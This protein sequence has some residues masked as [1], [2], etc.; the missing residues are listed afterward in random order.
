MYIIYLLLIYVYSLP[1]N[2][3]MSIP[4]FDHGRSR[5]TC[6]TSGSQGLAGLYLAHMEPLDFVSSMFRPILGQYMMKRSP[7]LHFSMSKWL[8]CRLVNI[9]W[10]TL[11][12][13]T[14]DSP[15]NTRP[16]IMWSSSHSGQYCRVQVGVSLLYAGHSLMMRVFTICRASS[17]A[18]A[19]FRKFILSLEINWK[20]GN[21]TV[22]SQLHFLNVVVFSWRWG[23]PVCPG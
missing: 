22:Y 10:R 21:Q 9:S 3:K 13:M 18:V 8:S 17:A 16:S 1:L 2:V 4:S 14:K 20:G 11:G 19:C 5:M 15:V 12:G 7:A 6:G 23:W